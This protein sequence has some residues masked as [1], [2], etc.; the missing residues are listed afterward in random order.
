MTNYVA[1]TGCDSRAHKDDLCAF[2]RLPAE[3]R[4]RLRRARDNTCSGC[5]RSNAPCSG[6]AATGAAA[7]VAPSTSED[8]VSLPSCPKWRSIGGEPARDV[9]APG[10]LP[11]SSG[12]FSPA[13][14][15]ARNC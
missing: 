11:S 7:A 12:L 5:I 2:D 9:A 8:R 1:D 10:T 15:I 4:D 3:I 13:N 14:R 6:L